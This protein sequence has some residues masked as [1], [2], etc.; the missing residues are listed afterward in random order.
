MVICNMKTLLN[1]LGLLVTVLIIQK[2]D[3]HVT[4]HTKPM[5]SIRPGKLFVSKIV[6]KN[7]C[8]TTIVIASIDEA[9]MRKRFSSFV[10][11]I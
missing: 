5:L 11:D 2:C 9:I 6:K 8:E 4:I 10:M 7:N 3:E 1:A